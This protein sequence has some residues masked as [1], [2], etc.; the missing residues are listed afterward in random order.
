MARKI[1]TYQELVAARTELKREV[2]TVEDEIKNNKTIRF[3][4]SILDGKSL[5]EPLIE[6]LHGLDLKSILTSPLGSLASTFF[7]TNKYV[8]KYFVA[9][10][11]IKETVPYAYKKMKEMID[12]QEY[13]KKENNL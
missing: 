6:S 4:S 11:I 13:S 5:K 1:T 7:L 8:R 12:N 2:G 9:F 3:T 10:S